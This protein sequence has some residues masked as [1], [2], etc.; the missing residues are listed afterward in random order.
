MK[1]R[2]GDWIMSKKHKKNKTKGPVNLVN[3]NT[4]A[5]T[6]LDAKPCHYQKAVVRCDGVTFYGGSWRWDEPENW[7]GVLLDLD[8]RSKPVVETIGMPAGF[9]EKLQ[10]PGREVIRIDWPDFGIPRLDRDFWIRLT[11][12]LLDFKKDVLVACYSGHGRTG[13]CLSIIA[14]ILG[15][16]D[17]VELVRKA[18]C[19]KCVETPRQMDYIARITGLKIEHRPEYFGLPGKQDTSVTD[20]NWWN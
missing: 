8:D 5:R 4:A 2:K 11:E 17:P 20:E 3:M 9:C 7:T 15:I 6:Y 13:T 12:A 18:L 1:T 19:S 14:G 10:A 16:K